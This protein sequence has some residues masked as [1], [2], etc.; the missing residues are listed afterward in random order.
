MGNL[1]VRA[2]DGLPARRVG[3]WSGEKLLYIQKYLEIFSVSMRSRWPVRHYIDLFSGPGK[4][5]MEDGTGERLGSPLIALGLK[6]PFTGYH[7]VE[8]GAETLDALKIRVETQYKGL[9]GRVVYYLGDANEQVDRIC[10][11]L[12][13]NSLNVVL[14]DPTG[15]HLKYSALS[16]LVGGRKA[17][18]IYLFPEGM[19][20]KR[21]EGTMNRQDN[22]L[23]D[24]V[25]GDRRW[26]DWKWP[27]VSYFRNRL[28][29]LG[30][31]DF[32]PSD[33]MGEVTMRNRKGV[34]LYYLVF[35]A[36]HPRAVKFWNSIHV[37][38]QM[39]LGFKRRE[40]EAR[41]RT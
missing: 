18:L 10:R 27:K 21:N 11:N 29:S 16:R 13:S 20:I 2:K 23:L 31:V 30:Y 24:D 37:G 8:K 26:R 9:S 4:C 3:D 28:K 6:H 39:E 33:I 38:R 19:S 15:L 1:G 25:M 40:G 36:K 7:F 41:G 17:D 32:N 35:A 34:M 5:V 14:V 22:S 12:P